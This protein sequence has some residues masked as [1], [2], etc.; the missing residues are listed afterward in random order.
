[1]SITGVLASALTDGLEQFSFCAKMRKCNYRCGQS[2]KRHG[3]KGE[4]THGPCL[5]DLGIWDDASHF[6]KKCQPFNILMLCVYPYLATVDGNVSKMIFG[7][8]QAEM[9]AIRAL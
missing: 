2:S 1:M 5:L 4:T 8:K 7:P 6:Q 3:Y 9:A